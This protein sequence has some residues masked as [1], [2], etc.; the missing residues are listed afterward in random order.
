MTNW[1]SVFFQPN[2]HRFTVALIFLLLLLVGA[3]G[4][5]REVLKAT[6]DLL[7]E[8]EI[9]RL[10][11]A[12]PES[13]LF[14]E[15]GKQ[16]EAFYKF[17]LYRAIRPD[18]AV[19]GS[20]RVLEMNQ[21]EF[22]RPFVNLGRVMTDIK[23]GESAVVQLLNIHKPKFILIGIDQY[24]FN[25]NW[26]E[27]GVDKVKLVR[28]DHNDPRAILRLMTFIA[29]HGL[30]LEAWRALQRG[31]ECHFGISAKKFLSGYDAHGY[32]HNG[33]FLTSAKTPEDAKFAFTLHK[34]A[35]GDRRFEPGHNVSDSQFAYLV[36]MTKAL[37]EA[38]VPYL[39]YFQPYPPKIQAAMDQRGGFEYLEELKSR[40]SS[41]NMHFFEPAFIHSDCDYIDGFHIGDAGGARQ[42][43]ALTEEDPRLREFIDMGEIRK[44]G[45]TSNSPMFYSAEI[46]HLKPAD[47]LRLG[48]R[49]GH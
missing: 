3:V 4:V 16:N 13:C 9:V 8:E 30:W 23:R 10:Q 22:T 28:A 45:A 43:A 12:S 5:A 47:F 18:I 24:W 39:I 1:S 35:T 33:H 14:S 15:Y 36:K 44:V 49:W 31:P 29:E 6:G 26:D 37:E 19:I 25:P 40:L 41:A 27:A 2:S 48:C 17:E 7:P 11:L 46:F 21:R 34:I 38:G 20:S 32:R 42:L